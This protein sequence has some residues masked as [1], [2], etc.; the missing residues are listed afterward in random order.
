MNEKNEEKSMSQIGEEIAS[1]M[2]TLEIAW[3]TSGLTIDDLRRFRE[4]IERQV[5]IAPVLNPTGWI[6]LNS[7]GAF[8]QAREQNAALLSLAKYLSNYPK[9]FNQPDVK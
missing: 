5:T 1:L 3:F 9:V 6:G 2:S 7:N 4:Y 8:E